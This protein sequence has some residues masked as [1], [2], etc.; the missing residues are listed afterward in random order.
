[1][2]IETRPERLQILI[3]AANPHNMVRLRLD[4]EVREIRSVIQ[5]SPLRDQISLEDR[6]AVQPEDFQEELLR[7]KPQIL[8]FAGHGSS[9]GLITEGDHGEA[10]MVTSEGLVS[11]LQIW[12]ER[13]IGAPK[14]KYV[15]LNSC[16]TRDV[17]MA[18]SLHVEYVVGMYQEISDKAAIAFAKAIYSALGA[19]EAIETAFKLGCNILELKGIPEDRIPV[20]IKAGHIVAGGPKKRDEPCGFSFDSPRL[21]VL[22][23]LAYAFLRLD[24]LSTGGWGKGLYSWMEALWKGDKSTIDRTEDTRTRGGTDLTTYTF[25]Y[26]YLFLSKI[27]PPTQVA[28]LLEK[29]GTAQRV[30]GDFQDRIGYRGGVG[31]RRPRGGEVADVRVRHSLMGFITFLLY[32]KASGFE[33]IQDSL[34]K[35]Y[36][37]LI[38]KIPEW[39]HDQSHLFAMTGG[40]VKLREMLSQDIAR[41]QLSEEQIEKLQAV[42]AAYIPEMISATNVPLQYDPR[43]R[44]TIQGP[45][46]GAMFRPYKDFWRMERSNFVMYFPFFV[47]DNGQAFLPEV[48]E[49]IRLRSARVFGELLEDIALPYDGSAP[50]KHLIR[51]HRSSVE[52]EAPRDWGLSAELAVLLQMDVVRELLIQ[53]QEVNAEWYE[54]KR[55]ALNRALIDTFDAYHKHRG[56]FEFTYG[57]SFGRI[58]HLF[59]KECIELEELERLDEAISDLCAEGITDAGLAALIKG[60]IAPAFTTTEVNQRALQDL[61]ITKLESGEHTPGG[62]CDERR[63]QQRVQRAVGSTIAFYDGDLG[64][65]HIERYAAEPQPNWVPLIQGILGQSASKERIALDVG[66]GAGQYA[67]LL[68]Q[69]GFEVELLDASPKMLRLA[70]ARLGMAQDAFKP[71]NIFDADWG[72]TPE[73]FDLIFASAIMIHVPKE[74]RDQIYSTFHRLLKRDG[75]LFVNYKIG[76]HTLISEDGRFFA[77]YRDQKMAQ[78]ELEEHGFC[79]ETVYININ[80]KDMYL[81]PKMIQW[82]NFYC[83]KI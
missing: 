82:A 30:Y 44:G 59:E 24:Q 80:N 40:A 38:E 39:I 70:C 31:L 51:Y 77:Y 50:Y 65:K 68:A 73:Y 21:P 14:V 6:G 72:Y 83:F 66:C 2:T 3:F 23:R 49:G 13:P 58:L 4:E 19:G 78:Q 74:K 32:G 81:V 52:A 7:V 36:L 46:R 20:L 22:W 47:K 79:I 75:L 48:S 69:L 9:Q 71:V 8:H 61:L 55:N 26:Y 41:S 62:A 34:A 54:Q 17:A 57:S 53:A 25:Y 42:L 37:Y 63:W 16:Y 11:L 18:L 10:T 35:T 28:R 76:D 29:N 27:L 67:K 45:L 1:M 56:L 15:I 5:S 33:N 43:P 60:H 12:S 64:D